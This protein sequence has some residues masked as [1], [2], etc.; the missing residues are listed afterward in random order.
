[1]S[2][3][4][5][6]ADRPTAPQ[7][8]PPPSGAAPFAP[9]EIAGVTPPMVGRDDELQRL[10]AALYAVI[11]GG[12]PRLVSVVGPAGIG[13]SRL[14]HEFRQVVARLPDPVTLITLQADRQSTGQPYNLVRMLV[15]ALFRIREGDPPA[16]IRARI[17]QGVEQ[18]LGAD[19]EEKAH[20]LGQ[21]AGYDF[22][23][24]P[25]L[26][27][28]LAEPKQ[29]RDRA[30][31][32]AGQ[33]VNALTAHAPLVLLLDDFHHADDSS[34]EA[35]A[36]VI[37]DGGDAALLVVCLAQGRLY[38][39]HP[40]WDGAAGGR[41]ERVDLAPLDERGGRRL[42]AEIMRKAG[43]LSSDLRNL[44]TSRAEGNPYYVEELIKMLIADGVIVPGAATWSVQ[45]GRLSR[46][47]VPPT[48]DDLLRAR[49]NALAPAERD[50]LVRAAVVGRFFWA[51]AAAAL[52]GPTPAGEPTEAL[53]ARLEAADLVAP[54]AES[55]FAGQREYAFR[56]ELLH[57]VAYDQAPPELRA[58]LHLRAAAWLT[59]RGEGRPGAFAGMI[60]EHHERGCDS[61]AAARWY[62]RA[63]QHARES[64][65]V[66]AAIQYFQT[67]LA[68]LPATPA[69]AADRI[70]CL[71]GLGHAQRAAARLADAAAY[72]RQMA[73][74]AGPIGDLS[75]EARA[76]NL[77]AET[78]DDAMDFQGSRESARRAIAVAE[79]A[80]DRV[81]LATGIRHLAFAEMRFER[82]AESR[83]L[84]ERAMAMMAELG[85]VEGA[86][87]CKGLLGL[88][89]EL[90]GDYATAM[91]RVREALEAYRA[92]GNL[93][94]AA[95]QLNN[96]G[97]LANMQGDFAG[98]RA[99]I[100]EGL[101]VSRAIGSRVC[102]IFLL[103]NLG[104]T[105]VGLGDPCAA[106][107]EC[108]RGIEMS[109]LSRMPVFSEF[110]STLS[111][112]LI[113]QGH[114]VE[115]VE[116]A[117]HALEIA[118]RGDSAR[119]VAAAWRALGCAIGAMSDSQGAPACFAESARLYREVRARAELG[120]VLR[121]WAEY[122][123]HH[124]DAAR[125]AELWAE[126]RTIFE[127]AGLVHELAR[128]P[129]EPPRFEP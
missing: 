68:L 43:R 86:A 21:L 13:K 87:L 89:A 84:A 49:I 30:L 62:V 15:A 75:A 2:T 73:A 58:A 112:A 93:A 11:E 107:A 66:A 46:L 70:A 126:A 82:G 117:Q 5:T 22:A 7:T 116:T 95:T 4:E 16:L 9:A 98:G 18:L 108:R 42:V 50:L 10:I 129:A 56:H 102:E 121:T 12:E 39:R 77:R 104:Q 90:E 65:S 61:A 106:E 120:R 1:M 99:F 114:A 35:V 3:N 34:V 91:A 48:L 57:E 81:Q 78:L 101:E 8:E 85:D 14:A 36:Q 110:Y 27:V 76:H 19:N 63:G 29:L 71:E 100:E 125:G 44:I 26:R 118:R 47:R 45:Q 51:D 20:L 83:A 25:H 55:R 103:S 32:Y 64:H 97:Y 96:L 74:A 128:T 105:L 88:L 6:L 54:V 23:D 119:E 67:A 122:E 53:L 17:E 80:G 40:G 79:A 59:A 124:G 111:A 37:R 60:A 94:E 24:S 69:A 31:L 92:T 123:L 52:G 127:G 33:C 109:E 41:G 113:C 38:E 115:A 72:F 28:P